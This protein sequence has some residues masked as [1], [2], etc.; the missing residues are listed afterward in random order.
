M[1]LRP[2]RSEE[3]DV[4]I[5][6]LIDVVLMLLVF[7]ML[8]TTFVKNTDIQIQLPESSAP[9]VNTADKNIVVAIDAKGRYYIDGRLLANGGPE[10]L[11]RT[12]ASAAEGDFKQPLTIRADANTT[13]QSV[14]TAMDVAGQLGFV[15]LNIV[16]THPDSPAAG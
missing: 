6:S 10:A 13:H 15:H 4:N 1:N 11:K 16:T 8:S 5:T 7:F 12:L 3:P 2:R 9:A 14:V